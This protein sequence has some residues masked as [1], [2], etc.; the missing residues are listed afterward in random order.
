[1]RR[2]RLDEDQLN[3]LITRYEAGESTRDLARDDG[4]HRHTVARAL[5]NAGIDLRHKRRRLTDEQVVEAATL[6]NTG[7]TLAQLAERLSV[8]QETIRRELVASCH[9]LRPRGG[10]R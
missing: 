6:Y 3:T 1:M 2:V 9:R 7:L 4:P 8:G 10:R 5:R